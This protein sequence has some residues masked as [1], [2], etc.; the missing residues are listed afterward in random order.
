MGTSRR[1]VFYLVIPVIEINADNNATKADHETKVA[2]E[3]S[4]SGS[5][6]RKMN[7]P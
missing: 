3:A 2:L 4:V 1:V 5:V 6:M 7:Y